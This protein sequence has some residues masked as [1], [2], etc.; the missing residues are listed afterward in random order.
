MPRAQPSQVD[1]A[2]G[3]LVTSS[4]PSSRRR[5]L[6]VT[7]CCVLVLP[8]T[9]L[10]G[11]DENPTQVTLAHEATFAA[12]GGGDV[13]VAPGA[14]Q[15]TAAGEDGLAL[16]PAAGGAAI[17]LAAE[18]D[19]QAE[20]VAQPVAVYTAGDDEAGA[21]RHLVLLLPDGS[22][23]EAIGAA[24]AVLERGTPKLKLGPDTAKKLADR[25]LAF[26]GKRKPL[27]TRLKPPAVAPGEPAGKQEIA[28]GTPAPKKTSARP[29][30][31]PGPL[32]DGDENLAGDMSLR[33]GCP[34]SAAGYLGCTAPIALAAGCV[35]DPGDPDAYHICVF[36][37]DP[38][39]YLRCVEL[40][41]VC[42]T[43]GCGEQEVPPGK[44]T[45]CI[46]KTSDIIDTRIDVSA[47]QSLM[48]MMNRGG[49][50]R[51]D[52]SAM[53]A[54][55]KGGDIEGMYRPGLKVTVD[56]GQRMAPP[57]PYWELL[58]GQPA[59]CLREP[60]GE[61]PMIVYRDEMPDAQTDQALRSAWSQCGLPT[62]DPPCEYLVDLT[63]PPKECERM[64]TT[65]KECG[66]RSGAACTWPPSCKG[67][68]SCDGTD[69]EQLAYVACMERHDP[70]LPDRCYAE[71]KTVD[72]QCA[73][74]SE[75]SQIP[76]SGGV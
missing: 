70:K 28:T 71:A 52:A 61:P 41:N 8:L 46:W 32:P 30:R 43:C 39:G 9:L 45:A 31:I 10:A 34:A 74:K 56:R 24:G 48:R 29:E 68:L 53:I 25:K 22:R 62:P 76:A 75:S 2:E 35:R 27:F 49:T 19:R 4:N 50:D 6:A 20:P 11:A 16:T 37:Q 38:E 63:R 7:A 42:E 12:P 47:Q 3:A 59:A 21:A 58:Q 15:V 17:A 54:A 60:A 72:P 14:Y 69:A 55:A 40:S 64:G 65:M 44:I 36:Q 13:R 18:A 51:R 33:P 23:R 1:P 5:V 26:T 66:D 57:R 73:E 67:D